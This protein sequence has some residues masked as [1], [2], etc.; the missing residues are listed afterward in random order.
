MKP[1]ARPTKNIVVT[2]DTPDGP[3]VLSGTLQEVPS[4]EIAQALVVK[5]TADIAA[6]AKLTQAVPPSAVVDR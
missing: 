5:A 4:A 6:T 2:L 1:L 3:Q